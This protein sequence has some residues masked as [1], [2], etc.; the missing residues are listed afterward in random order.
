MVRCIVHADLDAF[1]ASV[2]QRDNPA[3]RGR[4]VVVGGSS[5]HRGVVAAASYEARRFGIRS[6]M[7]MSRALRLC[8]EAIRVP[9]RFAVYAEVSA[10]VLGG[11]RAMTP[12]VEPLAL[13]EAYLDLTEEGLVPEQW[14]ALGQRIKDQVREAVGLAVSVG[15]ATSKSVAK[16]ASDVE[17]PDGLV[18]V[19]PGGERDFL[20]PLPVGRLWG[21]GP[22]G[23]ERM[24]GLGVRTIGDLALVD[25]RL[26]SSIF[27][28]WGG[29]L[30]ELAGGV[31]ERSVHPTRETKSVA[32]ETTFDQDIEAG[33]R[34]EEAL[35]PLAESLAERV[36]RRGLRGRTVTLKL[37]QS[38]FT[39]VTRQRT[40]PYP[41]DGAEAIHDAALEL[42]NREVR[43]GQR[44]RL[45]GVS[46]SGF[47]EPSQLPLPLFE[48]SSGSSGP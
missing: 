34:L 3:L 44:Y 13:D 23:E 37:R 14:R 45:L 1:Y 5:E 12:L 11:Y 9:A 2:E 20:A 21:V 33:P 42:L 16:I 30:H 28:R 40:L 27:G 4:P 35:R 36:Q 10:I 38:D 22:R 15:V 19:P 18:V 46:L 47:D 24:A 29:L 32:R 48:E 31:D 7:P 39:T 43:P 41:V 25:V 8:P 17:K 26:L 6:A